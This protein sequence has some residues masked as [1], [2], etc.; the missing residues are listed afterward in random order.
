MLSSFNSFMTLLLPKS[1]LG[2]CTMRSRALNMVFNR[3]LVDSEY[4][5]TLLFQL[6]RTLLEAGVP[7]TEIGQLE[8]LAP[9]S[10][11]AL[12]H[13]LESVHTRVFTKY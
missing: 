8:V 7:E 11:D 2:G 9:R 1:V 13:A 5:Q 4:R 10:L 3:A 6:R 12:A